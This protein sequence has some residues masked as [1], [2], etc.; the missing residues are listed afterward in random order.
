MKKILLYA[1][2]LVAFFN[3]HAQTI[4]MFPDTLNKCDCHGNSPDTTIVFEIRGSVNYSRGALVKCFGGCTDY[5]YF[6]KANGWILVSPAF[7]DFATYDIDVFPSKD[8]L[9]VESNTRYYK[10]SYE[11]GIFRKASRAKFIAEY[12]P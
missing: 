2:L 1:V 4:S 3:T 10:F 12:T 5:L 8:F 11:K 6:K 9:Y 7:E